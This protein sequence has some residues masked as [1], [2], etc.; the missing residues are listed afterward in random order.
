MRG[1]VHATD[2]VENEARS[3]G[4]VGRADFDEQKERWAEVNVDPRSKS[5][6]CEHRRRR[7]WRGH[8]KTAP[9]QPIDDRIGAA[10][11]LD[12]PPEDATARA[13]PERSQ[14]EVPSRGSRQGGA[15]RGEER[16]GDLRGKHGKA[17]AD[18]QL[19]TQAETRKQAD[20]GGWPNRREPFQAG[21][22]A[23]ERQSERGL[24]T[25]FGGGGGGEGG[26]AGG[27]L[28]AARGSMV[29]AMT[30]ATAFSRARQVGAEIERSLISPLVFHPDPHPPAV[31]GG[32][33][34][35]G[36]AHRSLV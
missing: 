4:G 1:G 33:N 2:I 21:R 15:L 36:R 32:R 12:L 3:T 10:E 35:R 19:A 27:S 26:G 23:R 6:G 20:F 11:Q 25:S 9:G 24:G 28:T 17:E 16:A 13:D 7:A 29:M 14:V 8:A 30:S 5:E 18:V 31:V 22:P 34:H